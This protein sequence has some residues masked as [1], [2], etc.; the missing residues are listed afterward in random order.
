MQQKEIKYT[1]ITGRPS[2]Y[3]CPDGDLA[4][5]VNLINE[6]GNIIPIMP[7]K[8]LFTLSEG[9][10]VLFIHKTSNF[11]NYILHDA[12]SNSLCY[13]TDKTMT[14]AVLIPIEAKNIHQV[15]AIGNTL[16]LLS[17]SGMYYFLHKKSTYISLGQKPPFLT[18]SLGI[19]GGIVES[20][21]YEIN[22]DKN[23]SRLSMNA[24]ILYGEGKKQVTEQVLSK[25][26]PFIKQYSID[27]GA[28]IFPFFVRYAYRTYGGSYMQSPPVLMIP[29]SGRVPY[30]PVTYTEYENSILKKMKIKL[31]TRG[32]NL[33][34]NIIN[35]NQTIKELE[36]WED[37][38]ESVDI[39]I[40]EP[41]YT[42]DQNGECIAISGSGVGG[43]TYPSTGYGKMNINETD[44]NNELIFRKTSFDESTQLIGPYVLPKNVYKG[45][46]ETSNFYKVSTIKIKDL[47][48][49]AEY[50]RIDPSTLS[51]L[52]TQERLIEEYNSHDTIIPT[53][54]FEYN[55]RLNIA[56]ITRRLF[57]FP[58]ESLMCYTNGT[59]NSSGKPEKKTYKY[60]IHTF[61]L[62]NGKEILVHNNN[63]FH[64]HEHPEYIFYPNSNATRCVVERISDGG[65]KLYADVK[66]DKHPFLN[67]AYYFGEFDDLRFKKDFD[68][69][70]LQGSEPVIYQPNKIYTSEVNNPFQFPATG[71]NTIGSGKIIGVSSS[72][73][74]LSQGQFG[75][76]P[77]YAF[78]DE[79]IWALEVSPTGTYSAKQPA[80]RDIC[81]NSASITQ[82][83]GAVAF[84]TEQGIM[85]LSGS[86]S[87]CVST[88]L[89]GPIFNQNL[90]LSFQSLV[91]NAE[92][93]GIPLTY[94][95]FKEF[96]KNC[97]MAYDYPNSRVLLFNPEQGY[98]YVYS[99]KNQTWSIMES[100]L[101]D[102][103]NSYPSSYAMTTKNTLVDITNSKVQ[104]N[105]K[106]V[107]ITRPLKLDSP[108][109]LKTITQSVH[110]GVFTDGNI[111]SVLYG[112]RDC[113]SYV[114][115]MSSIDH[116]IRS[117][118]GSP[119]KYFRF[120]IIA[121]LTPGE[122]LSGTSIIFDTKQTN[123]L[124]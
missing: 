10:K 31:S 74:A 114:P 66:L 61:I 96:L 45:I 94:I 11:C 98:C 85:L 42:Y 7:P 109:L 13:F 81:N 99:L 35:F 117:I 120:V 103:I 79:G 123:K 3:D 69:S 82:L 65:E 32:A 38:V 115:V 58:S 48:E 17:S 83:D 39:Y 108:D 8:T 28:F 86:E 78:T 22:M 75:Q 59:L 26:N 77:L 101:S 111:K 4:T 16:L 12:N 71:I 64:L 14:I 33:S 49:K 9:Q 6:N 30:M 19:K 124:R 93:N 73:K 91:S 88:I 23:N 70:T 53:Y 2:D 112:S 80:T 21:E 100:N 67:G 102:A 24:I 92:L 104:E 44:S 18:M 43:F 110:R 34:Y 95:P 27:I 113:I 56:N 57:G 87:K 105:I 63:N 55:S 15:S 121:E 62:E 46:R 20:Q 84:T 50:I 97:Q 29:N 36:K 47:K 5:M 25:I 116:T 76:F 1:G 60:L 90:L 72:T 118:H 51:S 68:T 122:S 107:I 119:Y 52:Q 106:G 41:I 37:V 54:S 40:S 89:D